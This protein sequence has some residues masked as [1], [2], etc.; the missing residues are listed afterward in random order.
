MSLGRRRGAVR[1]EQGVGHGGVGRVHELRGVDRGA[2]TANGDD[3]AGA[4][5]RESTGLVLRAAEQARR[6]EASVATRTL[7]A[8]GVDRP[9]EAASL[10]EAEEPGEQQRDDEAGRQ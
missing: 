7:E 2:R 1:I 3:V 6:A 10:G 9:G 8:R 4:E 5:V